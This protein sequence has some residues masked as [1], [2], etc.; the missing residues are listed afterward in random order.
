[1]IVTTTSSIDGVEIDQYLRVIAGETVT[2][3]N[4]FKD[5][6]AG[7]RNIVGG[8]AAGYEDEIA[9]ARNQALATLVDN[10][11]ALGAHGVVGVRI[12]Y[13]PIAS[14]SGEMMLV[15]ASGTAVTIKQ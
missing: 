13:S 5:M 14:Q 12:D 3:I 10:A 8:R 1:M 4:V 2:G 6:G 7:F 11:I 9:R 15:A